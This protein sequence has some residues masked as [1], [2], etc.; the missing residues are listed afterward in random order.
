MKRRK[1]FIGLFSLCL[2]LQACS[3]PKEY[4]NH[5][6]LKG[7]KWKVDNVLPF[8]FDVSD[9]A[10]AYAF[11]MDIRYTNAFP[12]QDLFLFLKTIFPDGSTSQDTLHCYLFEADGKPLGKGHR[13]KELT[14]DYS[15]IKFPMPG[16]YTMH[17]VQGM[18]MDEVEGI[19]SFGISLQKFENVKPQRHGKQKA[20]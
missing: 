10:Q 9:T 11:G 13:I 12:T 17:F 18:R 15:L 1:S 4:E 19:A 7:E 8:D 5:L 3:S 6:S 2:L 14:I 20:Q 16:H